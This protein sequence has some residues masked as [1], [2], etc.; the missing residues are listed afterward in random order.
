MYIPFAAQALVRY[1]GGVP[2]K[3]VFQF[4]AGLFH[5]D[6]EE[7]LDDVA[8]RPA[9][10]ATSSSPTRTRAHTTPS[11]FSLID[12]PLQEQQHA[13]VVD[14]V[15]LSTKNSFIDNYRT[16]HTEKLHVVERF[17]LEPGRQNLTAIATV[18]DPDTFNGTLTMKQRWFQGGG[19]VRRPSA[20]RTTRIISIRACSRC[21]RRRRRIFWRS[22]RLTTWGGSSVR[23]WAEPVIGPAK[24]APLNR[25]D[26]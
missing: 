12:Q 14:T 3:L 13:L 26:S 10:C 24:A 19:P 15:G 7:I 9:R 21:R 23:A 4:R 25:P 5:P 2:G 16:P 20:P 11:W 6:S 17:R 18:D 1:P 22:R 8:P